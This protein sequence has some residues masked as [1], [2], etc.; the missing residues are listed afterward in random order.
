MRLHP[1]CFYENSSDKFE[2]ET[3]QISIIKILNR[4]LRS[5]GILVNIPGSTADYRRNSAR[6]QMKTITTINAFDCN[7]GSSSSSILFAEK[8]RPA[9]GLN[10][11]EAAASATA[12]KFATFVNTC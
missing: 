7:G 9:V 1:S 11:E 10:V 2:S 6:L 8:F 3:K 4:I 12:D 5:V